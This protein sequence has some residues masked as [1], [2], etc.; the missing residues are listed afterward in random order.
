MQ[1]YGFN[2]RETSETDCVAALMRMYEKISAVKEESIASDGD[3]MS[4]S[5]RIMAQN[6]ETY[7]TLAK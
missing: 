2:I 6:K 3:V 5:K 7:E 1:A 4:V